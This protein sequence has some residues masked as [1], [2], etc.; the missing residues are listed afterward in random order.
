VGGLLPLPMLLPTVA[1]E[2]TGP[3]ARSVPFLSCYNRTELEIKCGMAVKHGG[4]L[5][6]PPMTA[7]GDIAIIR[8]PC[9][10]IVGLY[11][12]TD[13]W[14]RVKPTTVLLRPDE[15]ESAAAMDFETFQAQAEPVRQQQRPPEE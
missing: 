11:H 15:I 7:D 9:G 14:D 12:R 5:L 8:D 10:G 1:A 6:V 4:E 2:A 13:E 3:K